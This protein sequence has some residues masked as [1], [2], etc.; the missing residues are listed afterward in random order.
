MTSFSQYADFTSFSDTFASSSTDRFAVVHVNIRSIR[1]YW[2]EFK[3][4]ST[5]SCDQV[6]AFLLT[7]TNV[8]VDWLP[9]FTIPGFHSFFYTRDNTR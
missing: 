1:K 2:D 4:I 3:L 6:D 7:E 5:K 9:Q 8:S